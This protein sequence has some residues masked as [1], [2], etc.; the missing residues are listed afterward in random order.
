MPQSSSDTCCKTA[1]K[2]E[3]FLFF[4]CGDCSLVLLFS[5]LFSHFAW[6]LSLFVPEPHHV[7]EH[8][9]V[10]VALG[11]MKE[12][13]GVIL[14]HSIRLGLSFRTPN[15]QRAPPHHNR[16]TS[17]L[18]CCWENCCNALSIK[19]ACGYDS[20][21][22]SVPT[23]NKAELQPGK[24]SMDYGVLHSLWKRVVCC[25]SQCQIRN[26]EGKCLSQQVWTSCH[27]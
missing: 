4:S 16:G 13:H 11:I 26:Q 8:K 12:G 22:S 18:E 5:P 14:N 7:Y 6:F 3:L 24:V 23:K 1:V 19:A 27:W 15:Q 17:T 2:N 10:Y 25:P 9:R 20:L 21:S